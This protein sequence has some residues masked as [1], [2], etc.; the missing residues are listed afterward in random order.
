M[1]LYKLLIKPVLFSMSPERAHQVVFKTIR[2]YLQIPFVKYICTRIYQVPHPALERVVF[3]I[4]FKNPVGLAAGFDKDAK[5]VPELACFGFGHIEVGTVTPF[6]QPGN[7]KPRLFRLPKDE[8]IINR[9]GFNNKGAYKMLQRL[10]KLKKNDIILGINIGKNKDTPNE[11]AV[12][13]YKKCI[14]WLFDY[15]DYFVINVSSP[16]TP[17]LRELQEKEPLTFIL[18]SLNELN[19]L[20]ATQ[21]NTNR[22]PILLKIAPDLS[23]S[24]LDD[25]IE[26]VQLTAID[27]IIATNTTITRD[28]LTTS[29]ETITVM[30][31]GGM[32]GKPL[33]QK[34]TYVIKYIHQKS[35][36]KI[37]II[38]VGGVH[39]PD[40]AIEKLQ[41]GASLVQLYTGFVYEGPYLVTDILLHLLD[42]KK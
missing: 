4:K 21:K 25:I 18:N 1:N 14:T 20:L 34:S 24:Q 2:F 38:G 31:H 3:G 35:Q 17:H 40:D 19:I 13:D 22:K 33:R 26:I 42:E 23:P 5:R 36:G 16:N 30:G 37:P 9:M 7:E 28:S 32:S 8:A 39:S 15:A 29:K 12:E 11:E 27:G 10:K 6:P 41:A